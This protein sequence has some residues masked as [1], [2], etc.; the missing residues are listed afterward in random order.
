MNKL[1]GLLSNIFKSKSL[2][3]ESI[4]GM[5]GLMK[6]IGEMSKDGNINLASLKK[7]VM[8]YASSFLPGTVKQFF[9]D[10]KD[11]K[12]MPQD[13]VMNFFKDN[14]KKDADVPKEQPKAAAT[15]ETPAS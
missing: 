15:A 14:M 4:G 7:L 9:S 1:T 6:L 2:N 5:D 12:E 10:N 8:P 3:L 11:K 13:D